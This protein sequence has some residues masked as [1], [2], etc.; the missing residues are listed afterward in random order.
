MRKI[1]WFIKCLMGFGS[2]KDGSTCWFSNKFFDKHDYPISKGGDGYP[3]H[4]HEYECY[5]CH[6]KFY[7]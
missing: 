4:F 5:C 1:F 7:I 6:K 3:A 2:V